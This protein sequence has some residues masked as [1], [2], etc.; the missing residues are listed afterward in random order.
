[1]R[2]GLARSGALACVA[3]LG[4]TLSLGCGSHSAA[5]APAGQ[6]YAE[7]EHLDSL[8][9]QAAAVGYFD[10]SRLLTYPTAVLAEGV[11]PKTVSVSV[12]GAPTNYQVVAAELL[13]TSAGST[14]APPTDSV[15][16]I[17][18]W[19]GTNVD[20]L[21]YT[22]LSTPDTIDDAA[23][24]ADTI[25]NGNL[26]GGTATASLGSATGSCA[27][28]DLTT[29]EE[30]VQGATCMP[31]TITASFNLEY[32]PIAGAT[33][34]LFVMTSQ[35]IPGVRLVLPSSAGGEDLLTQLRQLGRGRVL[36]PV[37]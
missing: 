10:R 28:L 32:S 4:V 6:T 31:A 3:A 5:T 25:A 7:A 13:Q 22:Q 2:A 16:I 34:S 1:M 17:V 30:L 37:R 14:G 23:A 26:I 35:A 15:F 36:T 12:D 8:A 21:I 33:D 19:E 24:L 27:F 18:A 9:Q 20:E 29:A 11:T